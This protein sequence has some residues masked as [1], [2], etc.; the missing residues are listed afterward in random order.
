MTVGER[1]KA[2]RKK[3]GLTQGDLADLS[4]YKK[5]SI[6]HI[7]LGQWNPT[8]KTLAKIAA[9]LHTTPAYLLGWEDGSDTISAV[10]SIMQMMSDE[11]RSRLLDYAKFL[12]AEFSRKE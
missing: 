11:Y 2:L 4:G 9:A 3:Y 12:Y 7:E 1:I 10:E 5:T 6:T 8:P